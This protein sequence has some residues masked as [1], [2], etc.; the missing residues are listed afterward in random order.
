MAD[1]GLLIGAL[2]AMTALAASYLTARGTSRAALVQA[3]AVA[4]AEALREERERRRSTYREMLSRTHVFMEALWRVEEADAASDQQAKDRILEQ[5]YEQAGAAMSQITLAT[6]E[7]LLD[8]PAHV[9]ESAEQVRA[10]A[11]GL[12]RRLRTLIGDSSRERRLD[13]DAA[14]QEFRSEYLSFI[15]LARNA[16]DVEGADRNTT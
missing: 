11:V 1:G 13:Y 3:R 15:E 5:T 9:S 4:T 10:L 6:R 14:Y 12:Q 7:V 8:G 16:L 2:T